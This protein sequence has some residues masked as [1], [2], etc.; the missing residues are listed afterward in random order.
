MLVNNTNHNSL[1]TL[2]HLEHAKSDR[3]DYPRCCFVSASDL[4]SQRFA[5]KSSLSLWL[6]SPSCGEECVF[7]DRFIL[8][9]WILLLLYVSVFIYPERDV[10]QLLTVYNSARVEQK[11]LNK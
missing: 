3:S 5:R 10:S 8:C 1:E 7:T 4:T 11:E 9:F 2:L 6:V